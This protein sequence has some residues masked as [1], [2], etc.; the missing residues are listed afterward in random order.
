MMKHG[1]MGESTEVLMDAFEQQMHLGSPER[2]DPKSHVNKAYYCNGQINI[3]F[4][5]FCKGWF[6]H[7][8]FL[9][10]KENEE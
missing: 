6:A 2:E 9:A 10:D 5:T 1:T 8:Q 7:R 4:S 3:A